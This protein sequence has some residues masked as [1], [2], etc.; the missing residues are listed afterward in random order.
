[1]QGRLGEPVRIDPKGRFDFHLVSHAVGA[2]CVHGDARAG[3]PVYP[4]ADLVQL[5]READR[6]SGLQATAIAAPPKT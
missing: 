5:V 6:R 1:M 2:V 3:F 4:A